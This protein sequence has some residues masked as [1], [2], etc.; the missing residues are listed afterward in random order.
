MSTH[1]LRPSGHRDKEI[2]F[3][4]SLNTGSEP[5]ACK[6]NVNTPQVGL[7]FHS[8]QLTHSWAKMDCLCFGMCP[9]GDQKWSTG[10]Y[11]LS[12]ADYGFRH[13]RG[14]VWAV[15]YKQPQR[16]RA[17][18]LCFSRPLVRTL[19]VPLFL[20]TGVRGQG[21]G[22]L[23][24]DALWAE[25]CTVSSKPWLAESKKAASSKVTR[26]RSP[27][28]IRWYHQ[29]ATFSLFFGFNSSIVND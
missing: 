27:G 14:M 4:T 23:P 10:C 5:K 17:G 20:W 7:G 2:K 18:P 15:S 19:A 3:M 24:Q 6:R 26:K 11:F 12:T 13:S 22:Q 9:D 25:R 21:L 28:E 1:P 29:G 16:P 8:S